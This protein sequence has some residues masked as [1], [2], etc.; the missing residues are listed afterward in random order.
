VGGHAHPR[1]ARPARAAARPRAD[2]RLRDF[3]GPFAAR[4]LKLLLGLHA[5]R[6]E[7]LEF[8]SQAFIDGT[9]NYADD[10]DTWQRCERANRLVDGAI[11]AD[12][13]RAEHG[14]VLR[15]FID[16]GTLSEVECGRTS[17]SSSPAD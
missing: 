2:G 7:D 1:G 9:G 5:A 8:A 6:D 15:A 12:W 14:T 3:A 11:T 4:T 17:S 16:A 10:P 13:D